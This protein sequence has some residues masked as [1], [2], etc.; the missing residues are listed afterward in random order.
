MTTRKLTNGQKKRLRI[1]KEQAIQQALLEQE[2]H[3]YPGTI[4]VKSI[5]AADAQ[6]IRDLIKAD[7]TRPLIIPASATATPVIAAT[8]PLS[9]SW[10]V[11]NWQHG[12]RWFSNI[13]L[14]TIVA[15]NTAPIPPEIIQALPPH[16]QQQ[17][18]IGLA[19]VGILGRFINQSRKK[20]DA[21]GI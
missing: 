4:V 21:N 2:K 16:A 15:I 7:L 13:A 19:I 11:P 17:V 6:K 5:G 8:P 20:D 3:L 9:K 10:V 14:A 18:T 1:Q 12:W